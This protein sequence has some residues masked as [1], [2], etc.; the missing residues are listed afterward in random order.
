[1]GQNQ[2]VIEWI[3]PKQL[4][5]DPDQPRKHFE[6]KFLVELASRLKHRV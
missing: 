2:E 1:M 4:K 5:A 6:K 3:D